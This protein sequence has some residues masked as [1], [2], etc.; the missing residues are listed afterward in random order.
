MMD[1]CPITNLPNQV[2]C[3]F[4]AFAQR[5]TV[6]RLTVVVPSVRVLALSHMKPC[7]DA[8]INLMKCFPQ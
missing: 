8:A 6:A 4:Y 2:V 1:P 3:K 7:L 5:S